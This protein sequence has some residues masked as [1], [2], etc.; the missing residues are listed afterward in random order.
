M[1]EFFKGL[2]TIGFISVTAVF[3]TVILPFYLNILCFQLLHFSS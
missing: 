2:T 3:L 1:K